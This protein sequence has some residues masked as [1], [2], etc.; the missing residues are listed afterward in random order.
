MANESVI[1]PVV[2]GLK[3]SALPL[4]ISI[5]SVWGVQLSEWVYI[6]TIVYLITH[7]GYIVW[8]WI[9]GR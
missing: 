8:K 9:K 2:D 5:G 6:L 3:G 1:V 7:I 4:S